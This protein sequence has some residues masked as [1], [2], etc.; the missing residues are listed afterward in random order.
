A[1]L[2]A[3]LT[4]A[5]LLGRVHD[6]ELILGLVLF[7]LNGWRLATAMA[8]IRRLDR[9][10]PTIEAARAKVRAAAGSPEDQPGLAALPLVTQARRAHED[11]GAVL[12]RHRDL[13]F[14][15]LLGFPARLLDPGAVRRTEVGQQHLPSLQV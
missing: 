3:A 5:G 11:P 12:Q 8:A 9:I 14:Q 10:P 6:Y 13:R 2:P 15:H 4:V 7:L 1:A